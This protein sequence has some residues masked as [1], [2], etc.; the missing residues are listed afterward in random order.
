MYTWRKRAGALWLRS[1]SEELTHRFGNS[2]AITQRPGRERALLEI[3]CRTRDQAHELIREFGG[4]AQKLS[5]RW[6]QNFLE[7][8]QGK[9]MRIASRLVILSAPASR[10]DAT[11]AIVIPAEAAFGTG[12]HATTA[13]S[14]RLLERITR[15]FAPGWTMLDAGTGSGI[16]AIAGRCFGAKGVVAID[17]DSLACATARR[18]ARANR[19]RKIEFVIG[20]VLKTKLRGEFDVIAANLFNELLIAALPI[21]SRHLAPDG[22]LILSGILRS[23]EPSVVRALKRN[24]FV[25]PEIRRRGK[26]IALRA[27]RRK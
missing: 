12:H 11:R 6:L 9:P 2:L 15:R 16:L 8:G 21:W 18:N 25:T 4:S 7:Q 24:G 19:V 1:R 23:Q 20:D 14:L 17:N 22:I 10:S 3:S 26:W 27:Q 13:M 5:R